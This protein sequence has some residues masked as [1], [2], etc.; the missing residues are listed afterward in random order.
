MARRVI[1]Q[2]RLVD[3]I[4]EIVVLTSGEV[5]HLPV[6]R[7]PDLG[8]GLNC[9]LDVATSRIGGGIVVIHGDLP[10]VTAADIRALLSASENTGCAIA[11]DR[12][13]AGTNALALREVPAGFAYAF[14]VDSFNLHRQRL[15]AELAIVERP[16]L[17]CDIDT[18]ADLE[19][20]IV[21]GFRNCS[22]LLEHPA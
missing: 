7:E 11:P 22:P 5:D 21:L 20:A 17:A 1:E 18:R 16:G 2:L 6:R 4:A 8:R 9:E 14:G 13:G 19:A 12:H 3:E 10:L 15:P